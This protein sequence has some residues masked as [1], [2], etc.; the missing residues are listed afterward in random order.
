MVGYNSK[1]HSFFSRHRSVNM[2]TKKQKILSQNYLPTNKTNRCG[3]HSSTRKREPTTPPQ[4]TI[5]AG[6]VSSRTDQHFPLFR[7][8][9]INLNR[10]KTA[11]ISIGYTL[12]HNPHIPRGN[13]SGDHSKKLKQFLQPEKAPLSDGINRRA[14]KFLCHL[15]PQKAKNTLYV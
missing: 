4:T 3:K 9:I 12:L 10:Q 1:Y 2:G 14:M 13:L 5:H 8:R 11:R 15:P 6:K 7:I